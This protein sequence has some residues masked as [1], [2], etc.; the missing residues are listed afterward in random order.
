MAHLCILNFFKIFSTFTDSRCFSAH[1]RQLT[2]AHAPLPVAF[3]LEHIHSCLLQKKLDTLNSTDIDGT[4]YEQS[5]RKMI[6]EHKSHHDQLLLDSHQ[7]VKKEE[8][9][10][11]QSG[12]SH[13][14]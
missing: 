7:E 12:H 11:Q 5:I 14:G 2:R 4:S 1:Q 3:D 13:C 8:G 9:R 10:V 6:A